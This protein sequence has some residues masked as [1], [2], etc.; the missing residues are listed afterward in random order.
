MSAHS[1]EH[2]VPESGGRLAVVILLN[3]IITIAEVIGG[4]ISGSLSLLSDALHNFRAM[5]LR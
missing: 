4:I 2:E 3:L 1:H 5:A